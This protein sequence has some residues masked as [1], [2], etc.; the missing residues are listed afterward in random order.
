M[1]IPLEDNYTDILSKARR[2]LGLD[3]GTLSTRAGLSAALTNQILGGSFDEPGVRALAA[4]LDLHPDRLAAIGR[5]DYRPA[6]LPLM[7]GLSQFNTPFEDMTVNSYLVWDPGSRKGVA[8]DTGADCDGMLEA[9]EAHG[10][11]LELILLTHSH[12]DHILELD[13]LKERTRAQAWINE[14][15]PVDGARTFAVGH[16]FQVGAL[17]IETRSTWGHSPG[18][19][20]Y[21]VRGLARTVAIVGDAMFAGSMGGGGVSYR[22]AL[23]TNRKNILS[24]PGETVLCP[25]H[26]PLTTVGEQKKV[27]PFFPEFEKD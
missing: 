3:V 20:T 22:D 16:K 19:V 23:E 1:K 21:V 6:E 26:G 2:G 4:A 27:N 17:E 12:G 24:L 8:F 7:E 14:R 18:G 10:L 13:R 9:I 11:K 15:E 5:T 25:G